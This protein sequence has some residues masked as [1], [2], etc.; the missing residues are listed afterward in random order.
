M[1]SY[2]IARAGNKSHHYLYIGFAFDGSDHA[3][4]ILHILRERMDPDLAIKDQGY[5]L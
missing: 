2:R 1:F 3:V 4:N 5:S